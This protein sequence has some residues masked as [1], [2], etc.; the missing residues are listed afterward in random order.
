MKKHLLFLLSIVSLSHAHCPIYFKNNTLAIQHDPL[1]SLVS[2]SASCPETITAFTSLLRDNGLNQQISLVANRGRN[3][4]AQGS[5]SFFTSIFGSM[6]DGTSVGHGDF[7]IGYFTDQKEGLIHLDQQAETGKLVIEVI[8]WDNEKALYNFYELRGIEGG[9][10]RWFYRGNSKDAYRDN[11]FLYRQNPPDQPHFGQRMRCSACHN[12]GGPILKEINAPHNDW[13]TVSRP[14]E[15]APNRLDEETTVLL[16]QVSEASLL[17]N[18]AKKGMKKLRQSDKMR[19][20]VKH[21]SLQEQLRPLFCTTEI[22]LESSFKNSR[23]SIPSAFW[24]NPLL[25]QIKSSLTTPRYASLLNQWGMHFPETSL[26]DADHPWLTPVKGYNDQQAIRQMLLDKIIDK[27]FV[28]AVLM[29]DYQHPVFSKTRCE[30][31]TRL[32]LQNK[33]GW[34]DEFIVNLNKAEHLAAGRQLA[35]F[36]TMKNSNE[37]QNV[38][39]HYRQSVRQ[40]L[41]TE[42]GVD[43]SFQQLLW[44]R[45]RVFDSEISKN[46]L[47]Q[48][49]E[50]GFRVIFPQSSKSQ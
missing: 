29:I 17:A 25:G 30:L 2:S 39:R 19:H 5:F 36:L 47:G 18:D 44:L 27:H 37:W 16:F 40:L 4:P 43:A 20:F 35:R 42:R 41:R 23:V 33:S 48:I 45:Q 7:F 9:Q 49:L 1:F 38:I 31:L 26:Q 34:Q 3:N 6:R 22:N 50:P 32:P 28:Q 15:F 24:L 11:R 14:L 13:W 21:L 46:P 12:S 8:A 10:T